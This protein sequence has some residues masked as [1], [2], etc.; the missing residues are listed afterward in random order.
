M[1][2]EAE[3]PAY[4]RRLRRVVSWLA[5]LRPGGEGLAVL[6]WQATQEARPARLV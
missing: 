2:A 6:S 4:F 3:M 5:R 1:E